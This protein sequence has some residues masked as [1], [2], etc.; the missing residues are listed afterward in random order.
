MVFFKLS[1]TFLPSYIPYIM[2]EKSSS[3]RTISAASFVT[4]DPEIPIE[5]PISACFIAG[6]SFTP[7]PVTPTMWPN[8]W[9]AYT[10]LNLWMGVVL[11]NMTSGFFIHSYSWCLP[12]SLPILKDYSINFPSI[13]IAY[14]Y[15]RASSEVKPS[16]SRSKLDFSVIMPI[17]FAIDTAVIDWSPVIIITFTPEARHLRIA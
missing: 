13:E 3:K 17:C 1:N 5:I 14:A 4:S 15:R 6:A 11:E 8:L 12:C 9:Q 7:S 16:F 2:E 10:I